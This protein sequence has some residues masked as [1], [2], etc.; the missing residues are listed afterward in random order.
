MRR[1]SSSRASSGSDTPLHFAHFYN[2]R[3]ATKTTWLSRTKSQA[4]AWTKQLN[5]KRSKIDLGT[6]DCR[7]EDVE[8]SSK[9]PLSL[10]ASYI[11]RK[12]TSIHRLT[13]IQPNARASKYYGAYFSLSLSRSL[14]IDVE[15]RLT[16]YYSSSLW[17][18]QSQTRSQG[19]RAVI[20]RSEIHS[21]AMTGSRIRSTACSA[22]V[23]RSRLLCINPL[24]SYSG[25]QPNRRESSM[26]CMRWLRPN[27]ALLRLCLDRQAAEFGAAHRVH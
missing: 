1:S 19:L 21:G 20:E 23:E 11:D 8:L 2:I 7:A 4:F 3:R 17:R 14:K 15:L 13:A 18:G 9:H 5:H 27:P 6:K 26:R 10:T 25:C 12:I 16:L 24:R 22:P